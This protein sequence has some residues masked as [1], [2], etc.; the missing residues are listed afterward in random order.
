MELTEAVAE[1]YGLEPEGFLT[2]RKELVAQARAAKDRDAVKAI[3]GLRRPAVA[4]WLV[5]LL[6]RDDSGGQ[7]LAELAALGVQLREAQFALQAHRLRELGRE[8]RTRIADLVSRAVDLAEAAGHIVSPAVEREIDE[9]LVAAVADEAAAEA[10][11]S[12]SL[13]RPLSH[14]GF[15][16]VDLDLAVAMLPAV[17]GTVPAPDVQTAGPGRG[18]EPDP[19]PGP[20]PNPVPG[21]VPD[22]EPEDAGP[23]AAE[24]RLADEREAHI[25][26]VAAALQ[27]A[28]SARAETNRA[29]S[30]AGARL[31]EASSASAAAEAAV[32]DL[33]RRL[34]T[35]RDVA[36]AVSAQER[37]AEADA[38]TCEDADQAA[39]GD[40]ERL[41]QELTDVA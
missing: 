23:S 9:T 25:Q 35:A 4:A 3:G 36:S 11:L 24:L 40:V 29:A 26:E 15:G 19:V 31:A 32:S 20:G 1:L 28:E 17:G 37:A 30:Q 2:R 18:A 39:A 34:A 33:Q 14:S 5:N 16:E 8:R 38:R 12:G 27:T 13:T 22:P 6:R 10:V 41:R 21:P 7:G